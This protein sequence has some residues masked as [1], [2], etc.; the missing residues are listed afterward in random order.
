LHCREPDEH[1]GLLASLG[2]DVGAGEIRKWLIGLEVPKCAGA[3]GVDD[4]L[5]NA[6]TV[7]VLELL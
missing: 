6:F 7:E 5:G 4:A 3:A 1:G 2:K